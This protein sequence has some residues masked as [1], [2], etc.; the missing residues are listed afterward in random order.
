M[1]VMVSTTAPICSELALSS[2]VAVIASASHR[3]RGHPRRL[4]GVLA[5]PPESTHPSRR[6]PRPLL[7]R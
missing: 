4:V 3:L 5:D 1:L 2:L 6:H 7:R